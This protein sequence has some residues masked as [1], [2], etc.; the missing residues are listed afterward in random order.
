MIKK[1]HLIFV[2]FFLVI[3]SSYALDSVSNVNIEDTCSTSSVEVPS[4]FSN[5]SVENVLSYGSGS[6]EGVCIYFFYGNGCPHCAKIEPF[7]E[8]MQQKY[9]NVSIKSFEIYFNSTNQIMFGDFVERY[10]IKNEGIP[11]VFI[12]D[13]AYIG[14]NSIK[15]NLEES[16]QFFLINKPICPQE[17]VKVEPSNPHEISPRSNDNLRISVVIGA[18]LI[19]SINP[20][21]FSVLIFLLVYLMTLGSKRRILKIGLIY[22][23]VVFLVY[24]ISGFGLFAIVQKAGVTRIVFNIAAIIAIFAGVINIKDFFWYGKGFSLAIPESKKPLIEKYI[25]KST[26]PATIILGFLVSLFELPCTGGPYLAILGLLSDKMTV[27]QGI[28]YLILYNFIFVLPLFVILFIVY[29][30]LPPETIEQWR[31]DKRKWLRLVMGVAMI[32][33]GA[34]MLLGVI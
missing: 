20:C 28:P 25:H 10:K 9:S 4:C 12:G 14:D 33:L 15:N 31:S 27:L 26:I 19:D 29:K 1:I 7:I 24:F 30:G 21:A 34:L 5:K 8:S 11:A 16:I 3:T 2:I 32:V 17:Y 6:D 23:S 22:I 18:A 13:R